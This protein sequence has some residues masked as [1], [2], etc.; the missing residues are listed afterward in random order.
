MG[1]LRMQKHIILNLVGA[2][3]ITLL[4]SCGQ[5]EQKHDEVKPVPQ[6][7]IQEAAQEAM[8]VEMPEVMTDIQQEAFAEFQ[9]DDMNDDGGEGADDILDF[10]A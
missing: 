5:S 7:Q 4:C 1:D 10:K 2:V 3:A 6:E 9:D 8:I